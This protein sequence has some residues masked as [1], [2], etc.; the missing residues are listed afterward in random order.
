MYKRE[1]KQVSWL[2]D[3]VVVP[4]ET[5]DALM[6]KKEMSVQATTQREEKRRS[7]FQHFDIPLSQ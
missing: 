6:L 7:K 5:R 1:Q 3:A 2:R 4:V